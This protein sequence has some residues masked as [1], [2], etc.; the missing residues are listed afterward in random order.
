M[1]AAVEIDRALR[2]VK[3]DARVERKDTLLQRIDVGGDPHVGETAHAIVGGMLA[4][5]ILA[6]SGDAIGV[7]AV[8]AQ[9]RRVVDRQPQVVA[10][11]GAGQPLGTILVIDGRPLA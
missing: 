8:G 5:L 11:L 4:A 2:I 9:P 3:A 7:V 6:D 1:R 10:E